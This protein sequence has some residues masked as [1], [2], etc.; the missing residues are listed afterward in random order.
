MTLAAFKLGK[1]PVTVTEFK[2]CVAASACRSSNYTSY[3]QDDTCNYDRGKHWKTHP[4]TCVS[5]YGAKEYCEW[6]GGRLPTEEE[7]E[8][9]ATHNGTEHLDTKYPWGD[10]LTPEKANYYF[11]H[12]SD[13]TAV[14]HYSPAGDS[15]LGLVDM[16]GNVAEWTSSKLSSESDKYVNKG[17]GY[18]SGKT[19]L[20]V[21][22][23]PSDLGSPAP[24]DQLYYQGF[25]CAK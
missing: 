10:E 24:E 12:I 13:T 25:R 23:R 22:Y 11:S 19:Q 5:W 4:M 21:S 2:K 17:G 14:G 18:A 16:S 6:I 9:A 15:P 1:T 7:W 3:S 8:Y 20:E